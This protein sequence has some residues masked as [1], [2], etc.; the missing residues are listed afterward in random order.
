MIN[1][2]KWLKNH[3]LGLSKDWLQNLKSQSGN[4]PI[5][6]CGTSPI[7]H[8]DSNLYDIIILLTI[9]EN[10]LRH[11]LHIEITINTVK[12]LNN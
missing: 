6:I 11:V 5:F 12:T 3:R 7:D 2:K 10:T 8:T 9:D 1:I 4:K